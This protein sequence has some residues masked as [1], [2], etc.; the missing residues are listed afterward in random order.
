M[1]RPPLLTEDGYLL[2]DRQTEPTIDEHLGVPRLAGWMRLEATSDTLR[3][4]ISDL[5]VAG[6]LKERCSLIGRS[7]HSQIGLDVDFGDGM[8]EIDTR[9]KRIDLPVHLTSLNPNIPDTMFAEIKAM[10]DS[11]RRL[12][13]G[14]L[15][16]PMG[17]PLSRDA[18]ELAAASHHL[19]LTPK[20][21]VDENGI[22][23]IPL[24]NTRYLL[25]NT[26]LTA[27]QNSQ[28]V[29]Y[30]SKEGLGLIQYLSHG[31]LPDWLAPGN[32]LC[33]AIRIS[34]G[35][36]SALIERML[37]EPGVFHLA[38]RLLDAVRTSGITT[39]R[40]VELYNGSDQA[41]S[42]HKL[43]VRLRL[44]PA[45][46]A[47]A[48]VATRLLAGSRARK[49]MQEGV[50][51]ADATSIFD[52]NICDALFD[53]LSSVHT[54]RGNYGRILTRSK[55]IDIQRELQE[56][57]WHENAQNR[58]VYEVARGTITSGV[59][60]GGQ[61]MPELRGFVETLELVGG[62]Q[63]LRKV[64]VSH[65][66][67]ATDTLR[68]LKR[69]N[70]GVFIGR[71]I[72]PSETPANGLP[73]RP[74]GAWHNIYFGQT[75][76]ETFCD[77]SAREGARF[78]MIVGDGKEKHVR[79]FHRGFWMTREGKEK[80]ADVH[81]MIAMFGSH[82]EGT[83]AI[84]TEQIHQF[85]D[86]LS[87]VPEIGGCFAVCHGSGPGVMR[88]ADDA[89][90]DNSAR[91]MRQNILDRTSLFKI[92]NIGGMGTFEELLIAITNLK[93]FESLPAPHIFVDP[94]GL[95]E[96]GA[97]LW[98]STLAQLKTASSL[99]TIG[100]HIVRL[101]PA[102]VS[103]FCHVVR[104]YDAVLAIIADFARDPVTYWTKAG[105]SDQDLL[106][107]FNN[108]LRAGVIIPPYLQQ[109]MKRVRSRSE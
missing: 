51:F 34:L 47:T 62:A 91:H 79:E 35:P 30:E 54:E 71:S 25:S 74:P 66:F 33:G 24:E 108:A 98:E 80:M 57:E 82:V 86:Q 43:Q 16:V 68:V 78:Y 6:L 15:F 42:P 36:Y 95:G 29:L 49:I 1:K 12:T 76:Y 83:D 26:L 100:T 103:N 104:D 50:D 87:D 5:T 75:T 89:A 102:W 64:F 63:T 18:I 73:D 59:H 14:R 17:P 11:N 67:P 84:L 52:I 58:I 27:G 13:I 101:A 23:T 99:K 41:V 105:I 2:I 48:Q 70:V 40:Q 22:V 53:S 60:R 65:E 77:L 8:P 4:V 31:G 88:I 69:N 106:Q 61:I 92:Y 81:T 96:N 45:D 90:A 72:R 3:G 9:R 28:I 97:H 10:V 46:H 39:P 19:L 56:N 7:G 44:Y 20:S 94:F 55:C 85:F 21:S 93:L 37:N 32:F 107:A 38:A 109:A